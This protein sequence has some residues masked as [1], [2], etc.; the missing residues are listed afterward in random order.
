MGERL[1][2]RLCHRITLPIDV[3]VE[4][5]AKSSVKEESLAMDIEEASLLNASTEVEQSLNSGRFDACREKEQ[6][7]TASKSF[8]EE[9]FL[10]MEIEEVNLLNVKAE[11]VIQWL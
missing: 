3:E 7:K 2:S 1:N 10:A 6:S 5:D 9:E 4:N 11:N 8:V